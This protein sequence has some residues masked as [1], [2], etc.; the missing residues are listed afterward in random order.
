MACAIAFKVPF[1]EGGGQE[2]KV[3]NVYSKQNK[4]CSGV[5]SIVSARIS[6]QHLSSHVN[7]KGILST[8]ETWQREVLSKRETKGEQGTDSV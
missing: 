2:G 3:D 7:W 5:S 4:T 6:G 1:Q 8:A